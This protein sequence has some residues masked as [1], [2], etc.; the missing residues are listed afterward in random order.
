MKTLLLTGNDTDVGKTWVAGSLARLFAGEGAS[1]QIIKPVE[2]GV[3]QGDM[4]DG[5]TARALAGCANVQGATGSVSA[6]T[7]YSLPE[8]LA[9]RSATG[10]DAITLDDL[11]TQ[12]ASLPTVDW[13]IIEGAGG[14]MVP[15]EQDGRDWADFAHAV[16]ADWV[17]GVVDDR[18]GAIN[19]SRLLAAYLKQCNLTFALWLN[20]CHPQHE[21]VHAS[22]VRTLQ[23]LQLPLCAIQRYQT[24]AP[25]LVH[26]V[27]L[28]DKAD[29]KNTPAPEVQAFHEDSFA[30][31]AAA[32][33]KRADDKLER[34]LTPR[35]HNRFKHDLNLADNDYLRL[36][37][38]ERVIAASQQATAQ[39]GT[40]SSASPLITGYTTLHK[41]LEDRLKTW[42]GFACG[43]I[44]NSGYAANQAILAQLP[45]RGDLIL[46]DRFIHNSMIAGILRS[47]AQLM[48]YQHCDLNHLEALLQKH[49]GRKRKVFVVTES[50]FSMDGDY[51]D[52]K[53]MAAL[54]QR[55]A[56]FWIVDEAHALGWY[57]EHGSGLVEQ[58]GCQPAVDL[59]V[60]T[61]GK[62]LGSMGAYTLFH[63]DT[64]RRYFI[65]FAS[66]FIYST[67]LP[68]G[69]VAAA[70]AA[71]DICASYTQARLAWQQQSA[72]FRVRLKQDSWQ[73]AEGDSPI[74]PITMTDA[75][76]ALSMADNLQQQGLQVVAIRPPTVP[77]SRL[78]LS[79]NTKLTDAD[80][81]R[82]VQSMATAR[83]AVH[84]SCD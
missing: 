36:S 15:L 55:Y 27:W 46:A 57:G 79:L 64:L 32:V 47:G 80:Y 1:V 20:E 67:Y 62:G 8:P 73:V 10:G 39:W 41:Q 11:V 49:C 35:S 24:N 29:N 43:L 17:I 25:T 4:G 54:K 6:H 40:S 82:I 22:N 21:S 37:Q 63:N 66:E 12:V 71:V 76:Q 13:R 44:W 14:V 59:L 2:C 72:T 19:Q 65:N 81:A 31:W 84:E 68:P 7:F 53:A 78:R 18:L 83:N 58:C 60:G 74:V 38:E 61:L 52:F 77:Q 75:Q 26:A 34:V 16:Q 30:D 50:V 33:D 45:S 5:E 23:A 9:P 70:L 56:F 42:H 48:R 3:S 51:P 69:A 28:E